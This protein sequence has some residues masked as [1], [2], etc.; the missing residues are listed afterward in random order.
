MKLYEVFYNFIINWFPMEIIEQYNDILV[1]AT[2]V[3]V[4]AL[5]LGFIFFIMRTIRR[6]TGFKG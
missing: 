1:F 5:I 4:L 6:L 2:V 3:L